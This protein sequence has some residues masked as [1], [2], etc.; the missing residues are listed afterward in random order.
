MSTITADRDIAIIADRC[1]AERLI[2]ERTSAGLG[3]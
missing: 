2:A 3:S 1:V